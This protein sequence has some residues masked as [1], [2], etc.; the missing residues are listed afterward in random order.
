M[1][2]HYNLMFLKIKHHNNKVFKVHYKD[3]TVDHFP[4]MSATYGAVNGFLTI[5]KLAQMNHAA[6]LR[7]TF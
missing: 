4:Q 1:E 3:T 6:T 5:K 2:T 7:N